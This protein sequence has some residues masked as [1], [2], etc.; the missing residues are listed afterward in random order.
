M[1]LFA[2]IIL[3]I[4]LVVLF[5]AV[6]FPIPILGFLIVYSLEKTEDLRWV[7]I[8]VALAGLVYIFGLSWFASKVAARMAFGYE[9]FWPAVKGTLSELRFTLAFLPFVGRWVYRNDKKSE[10]EPPVQKR[11]L[12]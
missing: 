1:E 6:T 3:Q 11:K 2:Y 5:F 12:P 10:A 8:I 4:L 7:E 9:R